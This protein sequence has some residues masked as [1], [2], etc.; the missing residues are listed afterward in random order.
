MASFPVPE[1]GACL[2]KW[3][4]SRVDGAIAG[5][6]L[7]RP[8]H[9]NTMFIGVFAIHYAWRS[10]AAAAAA[11]DEARLQQEATSEYAVALACQE[12]SSVR[13]PIEEIIVLLF[14]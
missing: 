14:Y 3:P 4:R 13:S 11:E 10:R 8:L 1:H 5:D 12:S 2:G 6:A 9:L 7:R